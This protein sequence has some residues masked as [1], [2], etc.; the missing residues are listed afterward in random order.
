MQTKGSIII[1]AVGVLLIITGLI[2][3]NYQRS[4]AV[5]QFS[6]IRECSTGLLLG[7][8]GFIVATKGLCKLLLK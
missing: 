3:I 1:I 2:Y 4:G 7:I 6:Y 8:G 5:S